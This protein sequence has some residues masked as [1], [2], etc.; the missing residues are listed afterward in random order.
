VGFETLLPYWIDVEGAVFVSAKGDVL[1]R[2]E[3]TYDLRLTDRLILQPR[4]EFNLAAQDSPETRTGSGLSSAELGL[5]LRYEVQ[6]EFA[7]Y[8]GVSYDRR[9]G[10]TAD[11]ARSRGED[12]KGAS[13]VFGVRAFF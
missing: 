13:V 5:R 6:R 12:V 11:Y 3:G 7:P 10:Q 1:G 2:V 4:A 8:V 9:F